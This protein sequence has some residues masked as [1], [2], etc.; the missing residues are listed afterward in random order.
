MGNL[1]LLILHDL[2][3]DVLLIVDGYVLLENG[4]QARVVIQHVS[5]VGL[6]DE[7]A[8]ARDIG[9]VEEVAPLVEGAPVR[10]DDLSRLTSVPVPDAVGP[11]VVDFKANLKDALQEEVHDRNVVKLLKQH[12]VLLHSD[13]FKEPQ[14][15]E[16]HVL[17]L[18]VHQGIVGVGMVG[19]WLGQTEESAVRLHEVLKKELTVEFALSVLR[20]LVEH[21]LVLLTSK[22]CIPIVGPR[23]LKETLNLAFELVLHGLLHV[24]LLD[25]AEELAQVVSIFQVLV[26]LLEV[27]Q[28][29]DKV[30]HD[31]REDS[32][33]KEKQEGTD[34]PLQVT[35]WIQVSK[36]DG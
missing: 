11:L 7:E 14:H 20:H 15:L 4:G 17:V 25:G 13:R 19:V 33:S 9:F 27:V 6:S 24:E 23:V 5:P 12:L 8:A 21:L 26:E 10:S 22:G 28:N 34:Q 36:A 30:V 35:P 31:V 29:L 3:C 32:H 16:H 18:Y 2:A 1:L